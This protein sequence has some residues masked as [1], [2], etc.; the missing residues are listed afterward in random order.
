MI[1]RFTQVI[2]M[3]S[4][5]IQLHPCRRPCEY[6][7]FHA[8]ATPSKSNSPPHIYG[9]NSVKGKK[10]PANSLLVPQLA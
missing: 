2:G 6:R 8:Q 10:S 3:D 4:V 5:N 9:R 1:F 7:R